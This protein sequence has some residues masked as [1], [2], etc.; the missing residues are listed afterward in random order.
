MTCP[1]YVGGPKRSR[2]WDVVG[3]GTK[4]VDCVAG[5]AGSCVLS[6]AASTQPFLHFA[7]LVHCGTLKA[8]TPYA[9]KGH[10]EPVNHKAGYY[11]I[12]PMCIILL[13]SMAILQKFGMPNLD[14]IQAFTI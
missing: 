11:R 5:E 6:V 1:L 4:V 2:R 7:R 3:D 14:A 13:M 8:L 9:S 10:Q 12:C